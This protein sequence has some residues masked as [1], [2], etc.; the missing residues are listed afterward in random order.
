VR[1]ADTTLNIRK[2]G[3]VTLPRGEGSRPLAPSAL[4]QTL[5]LLGLDVRGEQPAG[6]GLAR[7]APGELP[8]IQ[9]NLYGTV[10]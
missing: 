3:T 4:G 8:T 5:S 1:R 9:V 6:P 10:L 2:K 7:G